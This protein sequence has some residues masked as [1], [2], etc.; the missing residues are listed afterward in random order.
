MRESTQK[1]SFR[2]TLYQLERIVKEISKRLDKLESKI[3]DVN[4]R[5]VDNDKYK[6]AVEYFF[7]SYP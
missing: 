6:D 5:T 1:E 7:E 4:N 2:D 3:E